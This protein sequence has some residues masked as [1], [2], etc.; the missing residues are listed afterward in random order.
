[1]VSFFI[2]VKIGKQPKYLDI[3]GK[4]SKLKC[5]TVMEYLQAR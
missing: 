4:L 1:M 3:K 2:I 5:S